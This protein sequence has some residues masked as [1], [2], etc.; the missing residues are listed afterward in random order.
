MKTLVIVAHPDDHILWMGGTVLR[1]SSCELHIFSLCNS[2]NDSFDRKQK[3]FNWTCQQLNVKRYE[4]KQFRDYQAKE[5]ME[6]EQPLK[7][8]KEISA[9]ADKEYD[10]IF[11]HSQWPECEYG[12]HANH[13]EAKAEISFCIF[14]GCSI[15]NSSFA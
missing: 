5:L 6:I 13:F 8:Q 12:F 4:A 3:T 15:S 1:L 14:R 2:R 7:M 10:I 9:F 11:T